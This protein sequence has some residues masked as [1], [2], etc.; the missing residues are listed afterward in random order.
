MSKRLSRRAPALLVGAALSLL[1]MTGCGDS[2]GDD[3]AP[4]PQPPATTTQGT[5][6]SVTPT[7]DALRTIEVA[8][9]GGQVQGGRRTEKVELGEEVRIRA[10]SDVAEELHVHT[11]D[12]RVAL[13]PSQ[14]AEV[15]FRADIPGR[16]EVEFERSGRDALTLEV[17]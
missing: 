14:P 12:R 4:D 5:S 9:A 15:V 17:S 13:Q 16:H 6:A 10:T 7:T 2:S 3:A 11:Y 8:F 1:L